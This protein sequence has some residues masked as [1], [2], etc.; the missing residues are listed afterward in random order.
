MY[1]YGARNY[2]PALGRW[3]NPDPLAENSR[4]WSPYNY[5]YNNPVYFID[6]DGRAPEPPIDLFGTGDSSTLHNVPKEF[7]YAV[8]DGKFYVFAH[9]NSKGIQYT[10]K[11]GNLQLAKS[12]KEINN[13]LS[14]RSPEWKKAM[15]EGKEITL[16]IYGCNAASNEYIGHE[17]Q[18]VKTDKTV[19]QKISEAYSNV[20]V[21]AA[22]GYVVYGTDNNGNPAIKGVKNENNNGGFITIKDGEKVAKKQQAHIS[23]TVTKE[24]PKKKLKD[25]N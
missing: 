12:P 24:L 21:I 23:S 2:D 19:A 11:K 15:K 4:R 20:T 6:P 3:M 7:N 16:T 5:A 18:T 14:E 22:D 1:D 13:L 8:G 17:G 10:D 25:E 9:A